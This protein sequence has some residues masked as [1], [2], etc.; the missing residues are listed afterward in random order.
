MSIWFFFTFFRI[1]E[2]NGK[3][4]KAFCYIHLTNWLVS[5]FFHYKFPFSRSHLVPKIENLVTHLHPQLSL[6][7]K[8]VTR[9]SFSKLEDSWKTENYSMKTL[10]SHQIWQICITKYCLNWTPCNKKGTK[11]TL[12]Q[13]NKSMSYLE[14]GCC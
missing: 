13:D 7:C 14:G 5:R 3:S 8:I 4:K 2:E 11:L 10:C 6:G 12:V 1:S 9:F